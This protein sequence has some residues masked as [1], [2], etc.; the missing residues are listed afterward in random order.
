VAVPEFLAFAYSA[1]ASNGLRTYDVVLALLGGVVPTNR[2]C[3][4]AVEDQAVLVDN[5]VFWIQFDGPEI[6]GFLGDDPADAVVGEY[7]NLDNDADRGKLI[8]VGTVFSAEFG[9]GT[10]LDAEAGNDLPVR[11]VPFHPFRG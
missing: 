4:F 3:G 7:L 8:A 10:A 5:D 11:F 2:I 1:V 6:T 9:V